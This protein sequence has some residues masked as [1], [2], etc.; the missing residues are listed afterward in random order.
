MISFDETCCV[1]V[2][3]PWGNLSTMQVKDL[4]EPFRWID[5]TFLVVWNIRCNCEFVCACREQHL[6]NV[7]RSTFSFLLSWVAL[8]V[9]GFHAHFQQFQITFWLVYRCTKKCQATHVCRTFDFDTSFSSFLDDFLF[10]LF[11]FFC[12]VLRG[13][14]LLLLFVSLW[15]VG[16]WSIPLCFLRLLRCVQFSD[17]LYDFWMSIHFLTSDAFGLQF[18]FQF[19][20][21]LADDC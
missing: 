19:A 15:G 16:F 21:F 3:C 7:S 9:H 12:R 5:F 18:F 8:C 17:H 6:T 1:G 4:L 11:P 13:L 20:Q 2:G 14:G 10:F